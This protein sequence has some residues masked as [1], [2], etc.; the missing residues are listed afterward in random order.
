MPNVS[1]QRAGL[2]SRRK[3]FDGWGFSAAGLLILFC[4]WG[5]WAA[6]GRINSSIPPVFDLL[7][8]IAV[9]GI[10]FAALR[11]LSRV[12]IE[13]IQHRQRPH[14]R[15]AHFLAGVY[16]ATVGISYFLHNAFLTDAISWL[17]ELSQRL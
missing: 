10:V 11:L 17:K 7:F 3:L 16:L 14:A 13:G 4:G 5:V 12:V 1:W 15:W 2:A 8:V 6:A 9:G